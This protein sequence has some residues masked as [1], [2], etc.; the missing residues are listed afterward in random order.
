[1]ERQAGA[2]VKTEGAKAL[3]PRCQIQLCPTLD[4]H[5]GSVLT[6]CASVVSSVKWV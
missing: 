2:Q 6:L 4:C 5:V 1:M 3:I